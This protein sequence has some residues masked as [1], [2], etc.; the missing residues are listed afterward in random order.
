MTPT[1]KKV[2]GGFLLAL[3]GAFGTG[4]SWYQVS[5]AGVLYEKPAIFFPSVFVLGVGATFTTLQTKADPKE[6]RTPL[7]KRLTLQGRAVLIVSVVAG[8]ANDILI[9]IAYGPFQE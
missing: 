5:H 9:H 8:I 7:W 1:E 3:V 6:Q 2:L 4:L